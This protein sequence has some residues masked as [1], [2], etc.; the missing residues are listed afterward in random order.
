MWTHKSLLKIDRI[1]NAPR[2]ITFYNLYFGTDYTEG[3]RRQK[4]C[5][6]K[7]VMNKKASTL[8]SIYNFRAVVVSG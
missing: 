5:R 1:S 3:N 2:T 8:V 6:K 7:I 4:I